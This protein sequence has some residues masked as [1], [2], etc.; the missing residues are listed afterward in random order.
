MRRSAVITLVGFIAVIAGMLGGVLAAGWGPLLGLDLQGGVAVVLKPTK[1]ADEAQIAQAVEVIRN[2]VDAIGVAEPDIT[3]QGG[4][5]VVQLPGVKDRERALELV[6]STAELR[7]RPVLQAF[8]SPE[9]L[10]ALPSTTTAP[11][12]S[13]DGATVTTA[14]GATSSSTSAVV[15][16][17][18]SIATATTP[19]TAPTTTTAAPTTTAATNEQSLRA[20]GASGEF[21]L[22][23][24]RRQTDQTTAPTTTAATTSITSATTTLATTTLDTSATP[25][26]AAVTDTTAAADGSSLSPEITP[27]EEDLNENV[28][29]LPEFDRE[30]D[31]ETLRYVLG[32]TLVTGDAL[33]AEDTRAS[34]D[35][36]SGEWFVE[37]NFKEGEENVGSWR[38]AAAA[39]F[40]AADQELCPT[41]RLAAVLDGVVISAPSVNDTFSA[42]TS[43]V[44]TG[45][46]SQDDARDLAQKLRYGALPVEFERQ[47]TQDV[48]A[49]IGRDALRAGVAAGLI[50]LAVVA[51]YI[52]LYY[53]LLGL[54]AL[55]SLGL[56]FAL[57]WIIIAYLGE[58]RGLALSLSGVV[59][60]IVSIG[61]SLDSNIVYFEQIKD[62]MVSGRTMRSS[63][64]R[65]FQGAMSTIIKADLV[66]LI[67]AALLYRLT[68]GPVKGFALFLGLSTVLDLIASFFFMRP[69]VLLLARSGLAARK[70]SAFGVFNAGDKSMAKVGA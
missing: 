60:I 21:A 1:A 66:S 4:N 64:Q 36:S 47:Q 59:G 40:Q 51:L 5:V 15:S 33:V 26:S 58:S 49:T 30:T 11:G 18:G 46:F 13:S 53:R 6:G 68:V 17:T 35:P 19:T 45:Q 56:S 41:G 22:G 28:V 38:R 61:V 24:P 43:A 23:P 7:F 57:L 32:P 8:P 65:A 62:D 25:T 50:G 69:A 34:I 55:A 31:K 20:G 42:G 48:S 63:A 14:A 10:A 29:I 54:V 67:G 9:A 70:P 16:T 12:V 39:C 52:V 2:R 27:R 3:I 37:I 44:I